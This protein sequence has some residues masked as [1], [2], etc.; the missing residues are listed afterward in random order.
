MLRTQ[1]MNRLH[2]ARAEIR[3]SIEARC[4]PSLSRLS[5]TS[6]RKTD[7]DTSLK[8]QR[9]LQDSVPG[10]GTKTIPVLLS[11][12]S[13]KRFSNLRQ[14]VAYAGL[15][16]RRRHVK[17]PTSHRRRTGGQSGQQPG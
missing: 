4:L 16:P 3:R 5:R 1:E 11:F 8:K 17:L 15:D 12:F 14:A 10:L 9:E 6:T 13:G 7:G 2:V